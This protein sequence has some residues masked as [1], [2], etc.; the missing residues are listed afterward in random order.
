MPSGIY[1]RTPEMIRKSALAHVGIKHKKHALLTEE[2]KHKGLCRNTGKTHF[3]KGVTPWNKGLKDVMPEPWNKGTKGLVEAWNKGKKV[4]QIMGDKN[5][6]W[7]GDEVSYT[8]LHAWVRRHLGKACECTKCGKNKEESKIEW[9]SVSHHAKRD[10]SDYISLC[11]TC[12]RKYDKK[13]RI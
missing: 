3:T 4:P 8:A 11:V 13:E 2:Q 9:A 7:K 6:I 5:H 12:H 10:L 1:I